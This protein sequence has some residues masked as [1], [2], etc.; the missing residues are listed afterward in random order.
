MLRA[1]A[2][3]ETECSYHH[4][5]MNPP[6]CSSLDVSV[7]RREPLQCCLYELPLGVFSIRNHSG[8]SIFGFAFRKREYN[9]FIRCDQ[10]CSKLDKTTK[11]CRRRVGYFIIEWT[12]LFGRKRH[13]CVRKL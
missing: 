11:T 13:V 8:K 1:I 9:L 3:T 4:F 10:T 5:S 7:L 2:D 6:Q 12:A